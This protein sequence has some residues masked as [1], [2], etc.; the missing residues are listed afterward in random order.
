MITD[1]NRTLR[2]TTHTRRIEMKIRLGMYPRSLLDL[3]NCEIL[4]FLFSIYIENWKCIYIFV[5]KLNY[6]ILCYRRINSQT[7]RIWRTC[8]EGEVYLYK[9]KKTCYTMD[10][11]R[12]RINVSQLFIIY[13]G[14]IEHLGNISKRG[15]RGVLSFLKTIWENDWRGYRC[16]LDGPR[17]HR[18]PTILARRIRVEHSTSCPSGQPLACNRTPPCRNCIHKRAYAAC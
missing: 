4:L 7:A 3:V 11:K 2:I 6:N 12:D 1:N 18:L 16:R 15:R 5:C 8:N 17:F 10:Y 13:N 9:E 14:S